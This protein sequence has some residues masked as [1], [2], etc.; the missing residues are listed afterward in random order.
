MKKALLI[1]LGILFVL[2]IGYLIYSGVFV[3]VNVIEKSVGPYQLV[4]KEHKGDYKDSAKVANEIYY[5]LLNDYK[6][7]TFKGFGIYYD[8]PVEVKKKDLRSEVGV[9]L[10]KKDYFKINKIKKKFKVKRLNRINSVVA[11]LPFK[12]RASVILGII[13]VYPAFKKYMKEK[14]YKQ[15]YSIEIYDVPNQKITYL[16]PIKK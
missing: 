9:I 7:E 12:T 6:I 4:F 5:T 3:S 11:E 8:D 13:K 2:I 14:K 10:E 15:N 16:I 1:I